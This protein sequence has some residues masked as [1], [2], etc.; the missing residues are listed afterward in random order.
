MVVGLAYLAAS[1]VLSGIT[2]SI[3]GF[4]LGATHWVESAV[5]TPLAGLLLGATMWLAMRRKRR[6]VAVVPAWMF[7]ASL[8][9]LVLTLTGARCAI[10]IFVGQ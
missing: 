4:P 3:Q 9:A 6:S 5:G 1:F 7:A 10:C 2:A 8:A